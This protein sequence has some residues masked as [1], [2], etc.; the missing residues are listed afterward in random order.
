MNDKLIKEAEIDESA[1]LSLAAF[2][3]L[4]K[5]RQVVFFGVSDYWTEKTLK[6][7]NVELV[8]LVDNSESL[9]GSTFKGYDIKS[10]K[11]L[12]DKSSDVFVVITSG[13]YYDIYPQLIEYGLKPGIDFCITP[14]LNNSRVISEI[15]NHDAAILISSPD[16]K[17]YAGMDRG[18]DIGGGLYEYRLRE[19]SV[20]KVVEGTFNQIVD[21]GDCYFAT[22][23]LRGIC[24]IS[25]EFEVIDVYGAEPGDKC[26]GVAYCPDRNIVF[27]G[28]TRYDTVSAH[29]ADTSEK[30]FEI[31]LS[32][33]HR[34][35]G[36]A[37]HWINDL[38]VA[39]DYLY[40]SMFSQSGAYLQGVYDG[41]ILQVDLEDTEKRYVLV[42]DAWMPH[43]VRFFDPQICYLDSMNGRFY[44]SIHKVVGEFPGF[45]R[46][47]GYDG[48]YYY[49]GQSENR[50]LQA[51]KGINRHIS[52]SAGF[53]L[54]DEETKAA[55]FFATPSIR[56]I[57]DLCVIQPAEKS[58]TTIA[59]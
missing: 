22:D 10:P 58:A 20:R 25:K 33:K 46:G 55:K 12:R 49:V 28:H 41:G 51:L 14:A 8:Y 6:T 21:A 4:V 39:G 40:I 15:H 18:S 3:R 47:L 19:Q 24:K 11:V 34:R 31:E 13:S 43:T 44:R 59:A 56:Q 48:H 38:H 50:D 26:M 29:N 32:G 36:R 52:L 54:F 35:L 30:L 17:V 27:L 37:Q 7:A 53:Y 57:H 23:E 16:H 2:N 42:R 5:G 45:I 1:W 9:I